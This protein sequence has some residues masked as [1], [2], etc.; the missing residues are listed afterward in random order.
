MKTNKRSSLK[1]LATAAVLAP[2]AFNVNLKASQKINLKLSSAFTKK[3]PGLGT[4]LEFFAKTVRALSNDDIQIKIFESG[5]LSK[6][7][8]TLTLVKDR[9]ADLGFG[10]PYYWNSL[11]DEFNFAANFPF[12]LTAED[13]NSWYYFGE[14][15]KL[16][17]EIYDR[18]NTKFFLCGNTSHQMG[19]WFKKEIKSAEDLKNIKYRIP[20][21]GGKIL[22][23]YY[24][25]NVVN[26]PGSEVI[27]ALSSGAIDATEWNNP[28]GEATLGFANVADYYYHP[29]WHEVATVIDLFMNNQSYDN[30]SQ[31]NKKIIEH[32]AD[33]T[34]NMMINEFNYYNAIALNNLKKNFKNV[35][36]KRFPD[37][38]LNDFNLKSEEFYNSYPFNEMSKKIFNSAKN[39]QKLSREWFDIS[40]GSYMKI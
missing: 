1:K 40:R 12:G 25:V 4:G 16:I 26:L 10:A 15:K 14:G 33:I 17:R 7:F 32:S 3:L 29:G 21:L 39:F 31:L 5:Q 30:L 19:G 36:I 28:Y 8:D 37:A 22:A 34:N 9:G 23:K 11:G 18:Q 24:G 6:P 2:F 35:K 27:Q 20:G 13:F 38:L